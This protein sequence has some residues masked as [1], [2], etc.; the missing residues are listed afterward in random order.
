M[1]DLFDTHK[2]LFTLSYE[3]RS[4]GHKIEYLDKN[5]N[6]LKVQIKELIVN[7]SPVSCR[8]ITPDDKKIAIGYLRVV[9]I[10]NE[11]DEL[12]WDMSDKEISHV[13]VIGGYE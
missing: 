12:V 11:N 1:D 5:N 7:T 2:F 6:I 4:K 3:N 9:K 10:Y 13:K 8:V